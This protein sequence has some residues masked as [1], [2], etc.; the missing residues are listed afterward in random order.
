M[1]SLLLGQA[2]KLVEAMDRTVDG[3]LPEEIAGIVKFHSKGA[4]VAALSSAWIP[5]AG[6]AAATLTCAGFIWTMYGRIG[7][8]INLPISK[9]IL[10]SLASGVATNIASYVVGMVVLSTAFSFI[11]GL[12]NVGA[13]VLMG[14]TC[15]ALTLA[16]GYVYL[17]VMTYL[18]SQ[19]IDPAKLSEK[20]L[21][22]LAKNMANDSDVQDVI[23]GAKEEFKARKEKGEFS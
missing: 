16:S 15:Y 7:A 8:E 4:A 13:S 19:G 21:K 20:E 5:G 18:F 3:S 17:K 14:G 23:K 1:D 6:G 10:K 9:N 2:T 12:G 22:D 11:P